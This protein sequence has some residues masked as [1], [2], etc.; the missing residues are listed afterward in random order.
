MDLPQVALRPF[1]RAEDLELEFGG[2]GRPGLVTALLARCSDSPGAQF[3]WT[4]SVGTRIAA[5]L[6]LVAL[7]E[8]TDHLLVQ[9]RCTESACVTAFE[10]E[11]PL[12][13][14]VDQ[15]HD[16]GPLQVVL[17]DERTVSL[18]LPTGE[19][20]HNWRGAQYASRQEAAAAMI[21]A[22]VIDGQVTVA[23]ESALAAALAVWDPLVA[24]RVS[25]Q[26]PVCGADNN[27]RVDL[28]SIAIAR[29]NAR[30]QVLLR[31]V[32]QLASHYGWTESEVLAIAPSRRA[33]YLELIEEA[34]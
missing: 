3:W 26:C 12:A 15:T 4:Q 21:G 8:S 5:L 17:P 34:R 11:L 23:D 33:R 19:D 2:G 6:R 1:G 29:L 28:E 27:V 10:M 30:Q 25:C 16:P 13:A 9:A 20:V 32:H 18:R 14:L 31:D 24:F 7:T 22:L